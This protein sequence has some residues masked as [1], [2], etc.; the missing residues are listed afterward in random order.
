MKKLSAI[1]ALAILL[2][3]CSGGTGSKTPYDSV[4]NDPMDTHIYT[5]DNG[6]KVYLS[7]NKNEPRIQTYIAV[8]T[9]SK[10]DPA[11]TTGLAHYLEHLLFKGTT[12]FGTLNY[13]AE[14]PLLD[15]IRNLYEVY[16]N[17]ADPDA[18]RSI[19]HRI[20]SISGEASKFAIANE[21]DKLM[22]AIGSEGSNAHTSED[23]T[24]Y[25]EDI[26]A[27]EIENWAIVQSER[28][29]D[30]VIR[31][32][33]TELEAVYEEYN[34]GLA[35]DTW[36]IFENL[37]RLLFPNHPYGQQTTIGTQEH[38]KNP[39]IVN[40]E[41]YFRK[42]YVP[43]NM[44]ICMSG[45]LD[46]EATIRIIKQY[47]GDWQPGDTIVPRQFEP[48]A[49]LDKPVV[50]DIY[51]LEQEMVVLGWRLPGRKDSE[52]DKADVMNAVLNNDKSG[53]IDI[54][55]NQQQR[56]LEASCFALGMTDYSEFIMVGIPKDGQT[57]DQVKDLLLEEVD[58]L[59]KGE[60]DERLLQGVINNIKLE[61]MHALESNEER[62]TMLYESFIHQRDWSD[63][64]NRMD[65]LARLTK[66]DIVDY[67][68]QHL[69]TTGYALIYKRQGK[70]PNEKKIDKPAITPIETNR[71]KDSQ[72]VT[73]LLARPVKSIKP[74]FLDFNKDLSVS[75]LDNGSELLYKENTLNG[76]FT[77]RYIIQHGEKD[78]HLL[79]VA[80][81]FFEYLGTD[82]R[83]VEELQSELYRLACNVGISVNTY[84]TTIYVNGLAE[85][86]ENAIRL[87]EDWL[88]NLKGDDDICSE[89][90]AD[91]ITERQLEKTNQSACESR[92]RAYCIWGPVNPYTDVATDEELTAATSDQLIRRLQS[93]GNYPQCVMYYGPSSQADI[94]KIICE[95]HHVDAAAQKQFAY[96]RPLDA[97]YPKWQT[98]ENAVFLAPYESKAVK[99][100][101]YS[102]NGQVYDPALIPAITLF[103]EYFGGSMN[104]IVFQ[105][106]REARGLAYSAGAEYEV[107]SHPK[108]ANTFRAVIGSQNDKLPECLDVFHEIIEHMP[109]VQ[110]NFDLAK[111]AVVKRLATQRII[112]DR[113]LSY[114]YY[115]RSFGIDHDLDE[116]IYNQVQNM[117]LED[118]AAFSKKN[119]AK[120]TYKYLVLGDERELD[121]K[122]LESLG[123]VNRLTIDE[124]FG[125]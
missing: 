12:Q 79:P 14:R 9:G 66:Q 55:L 114:Y 118:L 107:A 87:L 20:D 81:R 10:N 34:R 17:T 125:Y 119:V 96:V 51:G 53:L 117:T 102:N 44:A 61:D 124:I 21:Y 121:M 49:P 63:Q 105:E 29:K 54:D 83:T 1:I 101:M 120:R 91:I 6:L 64:V 74:R 71:G 98:K 97:R 113:V 116:D 106:L 7:V 57:L 31:G 40:I 65:R 36:K 28:F 27:N 8:R 112:A 30:M 15:S 86:Q 19:Y 67:A 25:Q 46:P 58:K 109:L 73:D 90:A 70:D 4:D 39:S 115:Y 32:F 2:A 59:Q 95:T 122:K 82:K 56:V 33:H 16:R 85:N 13:E 110:G 69:S 43:N 88:Q 104:A 108:E 76:T 45:D 24:V 22:A 38:L 100:T 77:L 37:N 41:N 75:T 5:L 78:D 80:A 50:K 23:E 99:L 62:A 3:G 35:S 92:L 94:S 72:F 103:N 60:F 48:E 42:Y 47:F 111:E 18:R 11:E 123:T 26:P 68:C 89:L 84:E 93:L 52:W